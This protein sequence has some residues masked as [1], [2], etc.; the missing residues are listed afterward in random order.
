MLTAKRGVYSAVEHKKSLTGVKHAYESGP[1]AYV[2][3]GQRPDG[4]PCRKPLP[5]PHPPRTSKCPTCR[6]EHRKAKQA[7]YQWV[8]RVAVRE[9]RNE[10][11]RARRG[12]H[13]SLP[14]VP[15]RRLTQSWTQDGRLAP[16]PELDALAALAE[17]LAGL[18]DAVA[19]A[20]DALQEALRRR[21]MENP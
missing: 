20:N 12:Y 19:A 3:D 14:P 8:L 11:L 4:A 13:I 18:Q 5:P 9:Q 16:R 10:R 1:M 2:C 21:A 6:Q 17:R 7:D 15:P